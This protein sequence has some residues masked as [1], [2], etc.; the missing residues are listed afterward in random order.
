MP[1]ERNNLIRDVMQAAVEFHERKLWKRFT[2]FDCFAVRV[3]GKEDPLLACVMGDAGEQYGLMLLQGS[4]AAE[5]FM[6]LTDSDGPGD[7]A[8]EAM[9][10]L[11][12]SMDAFG[13]MAP[14]VQAFFRKAGVHPRHD[15]QV[16]NFLVKPAQS[17]CAAAQ[18]R[19]IG[20]LPRGPE[21]R[22]CRRPEEAPYTCQAR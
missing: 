17:P 11:S 19:G 18:R 7:D 2:N 12:F 20:P 9:D 15:E 3:P 4:Q 8:A 21:G 16:S 10:M 6:A 1:M 22:G 5:S 13:D 14:E